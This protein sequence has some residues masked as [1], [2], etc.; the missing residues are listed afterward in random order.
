M[1]AV[2]PLHH[3]PH[4]LQ[5]LFPGHQALLEHTLQA[6]RFDVALECAV[7][8]LRDGRVGISGAI[9][10]VVG[11]KMAMIIEVAWASIR[12]PVSGLRLFE[13]GSFF[14][15]QY[16]DCEQNLHGPSLGSGMPQG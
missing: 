3:L 14:S 2:P 4:P 8:S 10:Q 1:L 5:H 13:R 12:G 11:M 16:L 15:Q 9:G 6:L 7:F